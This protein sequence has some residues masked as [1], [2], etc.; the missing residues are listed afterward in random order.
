MISRVKC[1][2]SKCFGLVWSAVQRGSRFGR[3]QIL[4]LKNPSKKLPL[5]KNFVNIVIER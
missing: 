4:G 3:C 5:Y 1:D 2:D